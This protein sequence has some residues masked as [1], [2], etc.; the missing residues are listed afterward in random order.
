MTKCLGSEAHSRCRERRVKC[1]ES[2]PCCLR[3][4]GKSIICK[5]YRVDPAIISPMEYN[6][7]QALTSPFSFCEPQLDKLTHIRDLMHLLPLMLAHE[8]K[9]QDTS[10]RAMDYVTSPNSYISI[11]LQFL[12]NRIGHN[13]ALDHSI[14]CVAN[15][16]GDLRR[17]PGYRD[18]TR[19]LSSYGVALKF[20]QIS[21]QDPV[22]CLSAE[23]LCATQL[24][25]FFE[26]CAAPWLDGS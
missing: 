24:L 21:L 20:L 25:G 2:K 5:G 9:A 12:P 11:Y 18:V 22:E 16:L 15:L 4:R 14:E 8:Q 23:V 3:C 1:D 13:L 17:P 10:L 19:A 26:V 6:R 7:T